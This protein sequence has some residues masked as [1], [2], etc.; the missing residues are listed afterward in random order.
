LAKRFKNQQTNKQK[1]TALGA[2]CKTKSI[3]TRAIHNRRMMTPCPQSRRFLSRT[4]YASDQQGSCEWGPTTSPGYQ[5]SAKSFNFSMALFNELGNVT[6]HLGVVD[7][8]GIGK[9]LERKMYFFYSFTLRS[10]IFHYEIILNLREKYH[11]PPPS[12]S[13]LHLC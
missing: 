12:K 3:R 13:N 7:N 1:H 4:V 6:Q 11:Y 10:F 5:Y 2:K 8:Y 9:C